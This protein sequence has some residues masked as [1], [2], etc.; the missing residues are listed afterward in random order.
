MSSNIYLIFYCTFKSSGKSL[1]CAQFG[2]SGQF[3]VANEQQ[4][5]TIY[6]SILPYLLQ[7]EKEAINFNMWRLQTS[8]FETFALLVVCI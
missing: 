1:K 5:S 3:A 7:A 8:I 6:A 4:R 2:Y